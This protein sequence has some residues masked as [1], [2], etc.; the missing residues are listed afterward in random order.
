MENTKKSEI[1]T[2]LRQSQEYGLHMENLGWK[3][4]NISKTVQI[5]IKKLGPVSIAKLQR[6]DLPI[7]WKD[8]ERL[9][10][11]ER[12]MMCIIEP[13][14]DSISDIFEHGFKVNK[15]P[16]LGTKTLRVDLRPKEEEILASFDKDCRYNIRK[17]KIYYEKC[18][19]G[20]YKIF[21]EIWKISAKRKK[22]WI[23]NEKDYFSIVNS[24]KKQVFCVTI[25]EEAGALILMYKNTAFYYYAGGTTKGTQNNLPYLVVWIAMLESKKRG[26]NTWDFEGIYDSRWPNK[27]WVGFTHFKKSFGGMEIEFPGSF[28][29]WRWPF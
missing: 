23:P 15:E 5:F 2:D 27:G 6:A 4:V 3:V 10:K 7:P 29:R 1:V 21:Y 9:L 14:N 28:I 8:T 17:C 11:Q 12:V 16:L 22:L 13:I 24:F 26:C 25:G 20:D 18:K 19:I